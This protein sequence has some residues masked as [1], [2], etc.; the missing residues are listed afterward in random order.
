MVRVGSPHELEQVFASPVVDRDSGYDHLRQHIERILHD[1]GW[2]NISGAHRRDYRRDLH[3]VVAKSRYQYSAARHAQSVSG[4]SDSLQRRGD[5]LGR[6]QL[7]HQI[8]RPD[9]DSQ[10]EGAR[11]NQRAQSPPSAVLPAQIGAPSPAIR[12]T[13]ARSLPPPEC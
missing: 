4:A 13:G 6:L 3:R 10:L 12:D 5:A 8:D 7:Y 9:V 1:V 2:L 11:R